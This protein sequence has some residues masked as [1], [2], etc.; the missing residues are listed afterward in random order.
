M[1]SYPGSY[2]VT[3]SV[4]DDDGGVGSATTS[5]L[6]AQPNTVVSIP[7]MT[8]VTMCLSAIIMMVMSFW[9]FRRRTHG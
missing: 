7:S 3:L 8:L 5:L 9:L 2:V 1:Y 4:A 6:V